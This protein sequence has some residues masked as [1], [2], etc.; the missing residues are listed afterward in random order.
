[1]S[2]KTIGILGGMG[3]AATADLFTKIIN[4]TEAGC[5]QDHLH[6]IIDSNTNIPDRTEALIHGGADPTEPM[7]QSARRLAE[8]GAE[9][10]VMPCNTAHGFYDAVCASVTVPV[11]HMIKLTAEELMRHEIT[12]AGLLAT[13]G[14]VQSGIYETCFAGSGIELITPSPE[15][16][17]AVMDLTYN[18]VKAGKLDFD[19]SGFEK[20]VNELFDKGA[21]TLILGCTELPPHLIC[22]ALTTSTSTPPLCL[23]ARQSLPPAASCAR[24]KNHLPRLS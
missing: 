7:T 23:R 11:L 10:I 12:R 2:K 9:L 24:H 14:T 4:N 20:A 22:T 15:A 13:D 1:M 18:G 21:Q 3:P 17:A 6:V 19:T 16:Q 8:A 5:D